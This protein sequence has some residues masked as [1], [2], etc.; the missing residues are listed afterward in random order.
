MSVITSIELG[1][2]I[3]LPADW[4]AELGVREKVVLERTIEGIVIRPV[5]STWD[6]GFAN[7]LTIGQV[8]YETEIEDNQDDLLF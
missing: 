1:N 3:Q 7:P 4:L 6:E 5:P 8:P 2:R